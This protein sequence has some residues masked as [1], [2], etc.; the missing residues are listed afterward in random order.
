M[1]RFRKEEILQKFTSTH[2][3]MYNH[4][5]GERHLVN[6]QTFKKFRSEPMTEWR[7]FVA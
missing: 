4:F 3:Q 2:A 1:Q 7:T 6:R 5:N